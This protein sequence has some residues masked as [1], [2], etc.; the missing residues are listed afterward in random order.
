[1]EVDEL[2]AT[3]YLINHV[4]AMK[5]PVF[6]AGRMAWLQVKLSRD[7]TE[8]NYYM[9]IHVNTVLKYTVLYLHYFEVRAY[10]FSQ[11]EAK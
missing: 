2:P 11:A 10:V 3:S 7:K 5:R 6:L 4:Y 9:Y 8:T 1:M